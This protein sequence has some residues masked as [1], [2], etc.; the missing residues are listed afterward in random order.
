MGYF[1]GSDVLFNQE[2]QQALNSYHL[3]CQH[4]EVAVKSI[5]EDY[6]TGLF[7]FGEGGTGK[8]YTVIKTLQEAGVNFRHLQGRISAKGLVEA[9]QNNQD[10]IFLIEDAETIFDDRQTA[11]VLRQALHS[12]SR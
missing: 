8:S 2:E 1:A 6:H 10:D 9:M 11:G 7:I 5:I 3:K 4:I 12:Q